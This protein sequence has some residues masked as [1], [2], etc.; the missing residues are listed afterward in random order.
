MGQLNL[1]AA[2]TC[3]EAAE[4]WPAQPDARGRKQPKMVIVGRAS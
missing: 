4:G 2:L 3:D 1:W